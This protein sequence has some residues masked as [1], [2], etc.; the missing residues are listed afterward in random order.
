ML[1]LRE[2]TSK[3]RRIHTLKPVEE[4]EEQQ[5]KLNR[6]RVMDLKHLRKAKYT[7]INPLVAKYFS[8][9]KCSTLIYPSVHANTF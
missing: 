2:K 7:K 8:H 4:E 1:R 9:H 3:G 5:Q 6:Q